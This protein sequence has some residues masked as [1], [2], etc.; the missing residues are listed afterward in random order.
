MDLL[1]KIRKS[2]K[3]FKKIK[4]EVEELVKLKRFY[5]EIEVILGKNLL[6]KTNDDLTK[7]IKD[8]SK[9]IKDEYKQHGK[10]KFAVKDFH[11]QYAVRLEQARRVFG[12]KSRIDKI[13]TDRRTREYKEWMQTPDSKVFEEI[14]TEWQS[15]VGQIYKSQEDK[16]IEIAKGRGIKGKD[17]PKR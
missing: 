12:L 3:T 14:A 1:D 17:L 15:Q 5:P 4:K 8:M 13:P 11:L 16:A 9:T 6:V 7:V 2:P 10:L